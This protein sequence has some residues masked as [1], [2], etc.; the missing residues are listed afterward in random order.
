MNIKLLLLTADLARCEVLRKA[1]E[2]APGISLVGAGWDLTGIHLSSSEAHTANVIALDL[3][4]PQITS[5]LSGSRL[6]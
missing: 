3:T 6:T 1:L 4:L 2:N 5:L